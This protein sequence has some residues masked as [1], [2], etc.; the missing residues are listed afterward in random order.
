MYLNNWIVD[1]P[2]SLDT[3]KNSPRVVKENAC[4]SST[5]DKS[6]FNHVRLVSECQE[7]VGFQWAG[8]FCK[9]LTLP[10]GFKLSYLLITSSICN[11]HPKHISDTNV[12]IRL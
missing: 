4:F 11:P 8:Y 9:F 7:L 1:K 3:L 5:D 12:P 6:G 10:F 2:F